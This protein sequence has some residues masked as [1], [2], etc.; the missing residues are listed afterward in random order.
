MAA[1]QSFEVLACRLSFSACGT[2]RFPAAAANTFRGALGYVL[3]EGIFRP[4]RAVGP[5]GLADSPRPFVLRAD[6]LDGQALDG[7]FELGLNLFDP[8][9]EAVFRDAFGRLADGGITA[10]RVRLRMEGW[11]ARR[12]VIWMDEA[13]PARSVSVRF[14]SPIELKGWDGEGVPPFGILARRLRDRVSSL[15]ALYGPGPL[16]I[17]FLAFGGRAD[18]VVT[19]GGR[20]EAV[21]GERRSAR[22]GMVHP[23]GGMTGWAEYEGE[24]GEVVPYLRAG[25]YTGAGRQTVWGRGRLGLEV[26]S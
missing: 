13:E 3:P 19:L 24:L 7:R 5:S 15:R 1:G 17:D 9:L 8:A 11:T 10:Q 26:L 21:K 6:E 4:H 23:L 16:E 18:R 12:V 22:T 14:E 20:M 25:A 2:V